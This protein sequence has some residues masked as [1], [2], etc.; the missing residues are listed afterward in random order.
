MCAN[1]LRKF[2]SIHELLENPKLKTLAERL[3]PGAVVSTVRVV[4]DEVATEV[5]NA[6]VEKAL[7]SVTELAERISRRVL[8]GHAWQTS[9]AINATGLLLHPELGAPPWADAA[10]E[11]M[12][13]ATSGYAKHQSAS[14]SRA[15]C[16][17]DAVRQ[18][19]KELAGAEDAL[20]LSSAA[21]TMMAT[22]A[23]LSNG[24][25]TVVARR[26]LVRR[27][28]DY[29]VAELV[30]AAGARR[31]EIG[32]ANQVALDDYR[33]GLVDEA[34]A[35][36]VVCRDD[37][38]KSEDDNV[39]LKELVRLG[40]EKHVPVIHDI[41]LGML[42]DPAPLGIDFVPRVNRSIEA[43]A[44]LVVFSHEMLGGPQCGMV[45]GRRSLIE[46]IDANAAARASRVGR[47]LMAAL[48]ATFD[49]MESTDKARQDI[50]LLR[51][52]GAS[53]D[54]LK[55]RAERMAPQLAAAEVVDRAEVVPALGS[56]V[57]S[58][59]IEGEMAGWAIALTPR[60]Q[61]VGQLAEAL[62]RA[63]PAV[64]G[65]IDGERLLLNMRTILAETDMRLVEVVE[66]LGEKADA[67]P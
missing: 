63:N 12:V 43:G 65:T 3:H 62:A 19:I 45:A 8:E 47:P 37:A 23:A 39:S 22:L 6:A 25:D 56:L 28:N 27:G 32:A 5:H 31:R 61:S 53:A 54:N 64:V 20:V 15:P 11:A 50:P 48:A 52:A 66:G 14:S 2:P 1:P 59:P 42:V 34:G 18:R 40:H 51:L 17:D 67:E 4:L 26:D 9:R 60:E 21:S 36:L 49:L 29:D 10:V 38:A 58:R 41:G 46:K 55:N 16:K 24:K 13:A 35:L 7:P 44:D 30:D 33:R 57:E